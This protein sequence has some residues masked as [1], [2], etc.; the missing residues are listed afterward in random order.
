MPTC[1]WEMSTL[2]PYI[3]GKLIFQGALFLIQTLEQDNKD[4]VFGGAE[5]KYTVE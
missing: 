3:Y 4:F 2:G 5:G 1:F